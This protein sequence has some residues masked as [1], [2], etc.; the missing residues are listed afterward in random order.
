V[1]V[2]VTDPDGRDLACCGRCRQLL[3]EAGGP[4]L[5]VNERPMSEWLPGAFGPGD[6]AGGPG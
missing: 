5:A 4:D 2:A 6:L 1:A 3:L